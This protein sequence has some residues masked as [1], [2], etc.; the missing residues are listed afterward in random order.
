MIPPVLTR[1]VLEGFVLYCIVSMYVPSAIYDTV[2]LQKYQLQEKVKAELKLTL[3]QSWSDFPPSF[4]LS[5]QFKFSFSKFDF[6]TL[7]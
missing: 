3:R 2:K 1:P 7:D 6:P 5:S 4:S